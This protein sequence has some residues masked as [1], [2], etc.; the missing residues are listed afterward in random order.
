MFF[1]ARAPAPPPRFKATGS[2][3]W[4]GCSLEGVPSTAALLRTTILQGEA[5]RATLRI[6]NRGRSGLVWGVLSCG[7]MCI[8]GEVLVWFDAGLSGVRC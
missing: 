1:R 3:P 8:G 5:V 7:L 2:M 6:T 4:L